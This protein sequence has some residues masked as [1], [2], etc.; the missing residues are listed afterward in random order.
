M[1]WYLFAKTGFNPMQPLPMYTANV[2]NVSDN[3][4]A[5]EVTWNAALPNNNWTRA[6]QYVEFGYQPNDISA[7]GIQI[8]T[9]NKN[10]AIQNPTFVDPTP[11]DG[12]NLDSD[13]A[14]LLLVTGGATSSEKLPIAWS[15]KEAVTDVPA[16][17]EPNNTGDHGCPSDPNAFQWFYMLDKATPAVNLFGC[18]GVTYLGTAFANGNDYSRLA[19]GVNSGRSAHSAQGPA[20]YFPTVSPDYIFF[21]SNF[22]NA[23]PSDVFITKI[24]MEFFFE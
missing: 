23:A 9:D 8:Y 17:T 12:T 16:A 6:N 19:K 2:R 24:V 1:V 11:G 21:E 20:G 5:A 10:A 3:A 18:D 15:I 13:P 14:G 7:W 4:P 22:S